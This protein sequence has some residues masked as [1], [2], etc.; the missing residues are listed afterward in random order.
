MQC[1][2]KCDFNIRDDSHNF[3]S[4]KYIIHLIE[5]ALRGCKETYS[6]ME[7]EYK[8]IDK[9]WSEKINKYNIGE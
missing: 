4:T 8:C 3:Y 7:R 9:Y 6:E 1:E 5:T 2:F